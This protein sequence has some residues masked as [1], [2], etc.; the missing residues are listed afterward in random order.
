MLKLWP[1]ETL[2]GV[3]LLVVEPEPSWPDELSP[4]QYA[5][6]SLTNPQVWE[7]PV[8]RVLKRRPPETWTG[9]ELLVVEPSPS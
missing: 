4:Q 2:T 5:A 8:T 1:P 9:A 6:P 7:L 3:E